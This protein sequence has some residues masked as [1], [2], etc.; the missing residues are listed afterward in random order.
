MYVYVSIVRA[1]MVT[2]AQ[3][4]ACH[5]V[6]AVYMHSVMNA[7]PLSLFSCRPQPMECCHLFLGYQSNFTSCQVDK[8][9]HR[10]K[11]EILCLKYNKQGNKKL[12]I[13]FNRAPCKTLWIFPEWQSPL[14]H[15]TMQVRLATCWPSTCSPGASSDLL[16]SSR[17]WASQ[18]FVFILLEVQPYW[19]W[20][21]RRLQN[22]LER[23][24]SN[25]NFR[26]VKPYNQSRWSVFW[27]IMFMRSGLGFRLVAINEVNS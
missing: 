14:A 2:G 1:S 13:R 16:P 8:I 26:S 4:M 17:Q 7:C 25:F 24:K 12:S 27:I 19:H 22:V 21:N 5:T 3:E 6:S 18:I 15:W 10:R 11:H 23:K 9:N 20:T